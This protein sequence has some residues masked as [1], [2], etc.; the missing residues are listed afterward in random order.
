MRLAPRLTAALS[1]LA[2]ALG[3]V[4]ALAPAAHATPQACFYTVL[5]KH[6]EAS[7]EVVEQACQL[8]AEGGQESFRACYFE[9]RQ[10]YVPATVAAE[11]CRRAAQK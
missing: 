10:D 4:V 9:L 6:P 5:E 7:P 8:G 2:L 11:A 3:G 1:G